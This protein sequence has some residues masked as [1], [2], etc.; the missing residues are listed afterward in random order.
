MPDAELL[1]A[2]AVDE[3]LPIDVV[4]FFALACAIT[5]LCDAPL[6]LAWARGAVPPAY[7][8]PLTGLGAFGPALKLP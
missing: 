6:A 5:W 3:G 1:A 8:L 7:A 4:V 2:P